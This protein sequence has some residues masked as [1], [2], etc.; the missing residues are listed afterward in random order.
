MKIVTQN[1]VFTE[2]S[3]EYRYADVG[4]F[5]SAV[6][7][8][9]TRTLDGTTTF[10]E[11]TKVSTNLYSLFKKVFYNNLTINAG[12]TL[13]TNGFPIFCKGTLSN[14]GTISADGNPGNSGIAG[15]AGGGALSSG[16][17]WGS[18]TGGAGSNSGSGVAGGSTSFA[19]FPIAGGSGGAGGLAAGGS[20]GLGSLRPLFPG[21]PLITP[22]S[23]VGVSVGGRFDPYLL[24][25]GTMA[26]GSPGGGG[27]GFGSGSTQGGGGG[28]GGGCLAIYAA[29]LNINSGCLIA[30]RGGTGGAG[31]TGAGGG[32]G[33]AGGV[34]LL[35]YHGGTIAGALD[36][37]KVKA[38]GGGFGNGGAG[39]SNGNPG[40]NGLVIRFNSLTGVWE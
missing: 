15:G 24:A 40:E 19:L 28:S 25:G 12:V 4:I 13:L 38:D 6:D 1:G 31:A 2:A 14:S 37:S 16:E 7:N 21:P 22:K 36:T 29:I 18:G 23:A 35:V 3:L 27:G 9:A 10:P 26:S 39:A 20:K 32:G 33:G 17:F 34:I 5:G 30:A 11:L 8:G